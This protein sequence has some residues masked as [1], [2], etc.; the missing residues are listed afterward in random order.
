MRQTPVALALGV[1]K[2]DPLCAESSDGSITAGGSGGSGALGYSIGGAFQ[3]S[4]SFTG[5]AA[6]TYTVTL[7]DANG[8]STS[9]DITLQAPPALAPL[10]DKADPPCGAA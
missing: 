3:A 5:L 1:D 7:K 6:G 4:G 2:A 10:L 9:K 8:C